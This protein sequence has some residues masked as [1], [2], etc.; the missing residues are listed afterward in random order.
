MG[1][2]KIGDINLNGIATLAP[3]AGITDRAFREICS[4]FG[5][6]CFTS[7]M[8]STKGLIYDSKKTFSLIEHSDLERPFAVQLF[9]NNPDDFYKSVEIILKKYKNIDIIDINMGCPAP[10][11]IKE[12]SG[13]ALMKTPE[14][15]GN[16]VRA[17]KKS[18]NNTCDFNMP[19]TVKIRAG[20]STNNLNAPEVAKI[21]E[22][23][24]AD[25][26][27]VHGRTKEQLYSGKNN[28]DIIKQVKKSVALPVIGNGDVNSLESAQ[29]MISYTNC[30][31]VAIGRA[32]VGNPWIF[33]Q[34]NNNLNNN[35]SFEE[36]SRVLKLHI[37]KLC[38]YKTENTGIKE[39]RKHVSA[40]LKN[41]PNACELRK[42][43]FS[44]QNKLELFE[45]CDLI[46]NY[47]CYFLP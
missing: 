32:S 27:T 22:Q 6:A 40:Y 7:E 24:G 15:C 31:L 44:A 41:F 28:L 20:W 37:D 12:N 43:V 10:K 35:I 18:I 14:L 39:A 13:S 29:N 16:I 4:E 2:I 45:I 17:V 38:E 34:I 25:L 3:M 33:A 11:I 36:K 26:I 42:K 5:V 21:C 19:V 1:C 47:H 8:V 46:K 30:D 23:S 9:G